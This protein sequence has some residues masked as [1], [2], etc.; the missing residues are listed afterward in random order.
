MERNL[1]SVRLAAEVATRPGLE[2][3]GFGPNQVAVLQVGGSPG[4]IA[5]LKRGS[6]YG[7]ILSA[8][9]V[10]G[11]SADPRSNLRL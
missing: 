7:S 6:V 1:Q 4:R 10:I 8:N 9:K 5:A 11:A 2:K 3:A